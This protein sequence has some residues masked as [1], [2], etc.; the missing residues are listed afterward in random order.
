MN[1]NIATVVRYLTLALVVLSFFGCKT[2]P[3]PP[4]PPPPPQ[5]AS[6]SPLSFNESVHVATRALMLQ[7]KQQEDVVRI[8]TD[9]AIFML[10]PVVDANTAEV[11][12]S[13]V[14]VEAILREEAA[15]LS[16]RYVFVPLNLDNYDMAKYVVSGTILYSSFASETGGE[17]KMYKLALAVIDLKSGRVVASS[18]AWIADKKIDVTPVASYQDIPVYIKDK[19]VEGQI[20]TAQ[21]SPG[22]QANPDY[23]DSLP[24]A[25]LLVQADIAYEAMR[26]E[27]ALGMYKAV[28]LRA[29]GQIMKTYAGLYLTNRKLQKVSAA[30]IAFGQLINIAY[31]NNNI[32]IKL[33]FGVKSS[34]FINDAEIRSQ[35]E[36]WLRQI[37]KLFSR[38]SGCLIIAGHSSHSGSEGF[39]E[40]LSLKR[41][42][43][44]R[45]LMQKDFPQIHQRSRVVGLGWKENIIGSGTDDAQDAIDRRVEF[46]LEECSKP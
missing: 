20:E 37:A 39:N 7:V 32:N 34:E 17:S 24:T 31:Q 8:A 41:A 18:E 11:N 13:S 38:N 1:R 21:M 4:P 42:T 15:Q 33:L 19:R 30:E 9:K 23:F 26:F 46:K 44:V 40:Q 28:S 27:Q 6:S 25:S 14:A 29:D 22:Q 2:P 10:D 16:D 43:A 12:K 3:P 5:K 35:Y 36:M 45:K